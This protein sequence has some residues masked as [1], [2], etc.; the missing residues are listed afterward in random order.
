MKVGIGVEER[1]RKTVGM[2]KGG[3]YI[4]SV[5]CGGR[6]VRYAT[7]SLQRENTIDLISI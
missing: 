3:T 7:S 5:Q 4:G 2:R 6:Q 1:H